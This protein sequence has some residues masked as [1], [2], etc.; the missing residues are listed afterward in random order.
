[1]DKQ[2]ERIE[3]KYTACFVPEATLA[4]SEL[5]C[6]REGRIRPSQSFAEKGQP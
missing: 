5:V 6:L 2:R 4:D 3:M 1:M